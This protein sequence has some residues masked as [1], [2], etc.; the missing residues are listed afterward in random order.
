LNP[1]EVVNKKL[2]ENGKRYKNGFNLQCKLLSVFTCNKEDYLVIRSCRHNG[3]TEMIKALAIDGYSVHDP[4]SMQT[5]GNRLLDTRLATVK[6]FEVV[7]GE[8]SSFIYPI[9]VKTKNGAL[10][11][12]AQSSKVQSVLAFLKKRKR[13]AEADEARS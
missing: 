9:I 3:G 10:G 8:Q 1:G 12:P 11:L 13:D 4:L 2:R 7:P 6:C 5:Q